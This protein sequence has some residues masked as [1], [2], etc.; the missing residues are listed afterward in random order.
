MKNIITSFS[1]TESQP[2]KSSIALLQTACIGDSF[3]HIALFRAVCKSELGNNS[4]V[5]VAANVAWKLKHFCWLLLLR[6]VMLWTNERTQQ[7]IL[8]KSVEFSFRL[9]ENI[10]TNVI[11]KVYQK[12]VI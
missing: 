10:F 3:M 11:I 1:C 8:V 9:A 5:P 2:Q 4:C 12:D 6:Q 7:N